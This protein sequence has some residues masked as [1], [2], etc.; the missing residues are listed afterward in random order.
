MEKRLDLKGKIVVLRNA[1]PSD[2]Q[3]IVDYIHIAAGETDNLSFGA[4]DVPINLENEIEYLTSVQN[5]LSSA[6]FVAIYEGEVIASSNINAKARPRMAHVG[7]L[8]ISVRKDFWH[9]GIGYALMDMM[10]VWAK[11]TGILRKINLTV[12]S[13]NPN[14]IALYNKCGFTYVGTLHDEMRVDGIS[15]HLDAME[16]LFDHVG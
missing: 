4:D 13:D 12:R 7:S 15:V 11:S 8:G 5:S 10:I 9:L 16:L 6:H 3:A 2:A 1:I 14:A